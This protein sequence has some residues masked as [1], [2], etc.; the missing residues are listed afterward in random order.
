M[1]C[2]AA[3]I[4][5]IDL[6]GD[7]LHSNHSSVSCG[8][9]LSYS[10]ACSIAYHCCYTDKCNTYEST[11][12]SILLSSSSSSTIFIFERIVINFSI[13]LIYHWFLQ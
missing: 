9:T 6:R 7:R 11:F 8:Q 13:L 12:I 3:D 5:I 1:N 4:H 10:S 2:L